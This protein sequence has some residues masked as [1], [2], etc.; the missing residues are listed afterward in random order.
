MANITVTQYVAHNQPNRADLILRNTGRM[1]QI[2]TKAYLSTQSSKQMFAKTA[3]VLASTGICMG[4]GAGVGAI[5]GGVGA[6][7]GGFIGAE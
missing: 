7:P 1:R 5:E 6:L 2:D 4:I 3:T